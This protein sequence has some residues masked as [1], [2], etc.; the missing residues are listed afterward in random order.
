MVLKITSSRP[1]S[2]DSNSGNDP[3]PAFVMKGGKV[4]VD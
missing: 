4:V 3:H 2:A 1:F